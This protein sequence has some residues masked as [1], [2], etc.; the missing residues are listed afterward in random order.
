MLAVLGLV[1]GCNNSI[2]QSGPA[3]E[4]ALKTRRQAPAPFDHR[5]GK[6]TQACAGEEV[7]RGCMWTGQDSVPSTPVALATSPTPSQAPAC[8]VQGNPQLSNAHLDFSIRKVGDQDP[9]YTKAKGSES[10]IPF[11]ALP[12]CSSGHLPATPQLTQSQRDH[13][14]TREPHCLSCP[15]AKWGL[16]VPRPI[17][18]PVTT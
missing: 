7:A 18:V 12:C 4:M 3:T 5:K 14:T 2:T 17:G 10:R 9:R 13:G 6:A 11:P 8:S 1:V 15:R 16:P